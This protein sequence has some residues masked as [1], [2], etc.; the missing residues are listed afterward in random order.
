M[1]FKQL[2]DLQILGISGTFA[3]ICGAL[4]YLV[5]VEEGKPFEWW[6]LFLHTA[7]SAMFGLIAFE[8]LSFEGFPPELAGALCGIAG[9]G[10]TRIAR[11]FEVLFRKRAGITKE[12][13]EKF[14]D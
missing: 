1:P 9:W 5:K 7:T 14:G 10:G 13:M 2:T 4:S 12:D 3:G 11:I 8:V 6:E